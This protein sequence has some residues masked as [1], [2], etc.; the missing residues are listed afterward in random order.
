MRSLS[1]LLADR[2]GSA[3]LEFAVVAPFLVVMMVGVFEGTEL[4]RA[5]MKVEHAAGLLVKMVAQQTASVTGGTS[6]TLGDLCTGAKLSMTPLPAGSF[7]SAIASLTKPQNGSNAAEDWES[8]T[9]CAT[10]STVLSASAVDLARKFVPNAGDS[11]IIASATYTYVA[12]T[13]LVL[14]SSYILTSVAYAR[15]RVNSTIVCTNTS[16]PDC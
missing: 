8:D 12:P 1:R 7:A 10:R 2:R 14:K 4:Y 11:V 3:A 9:S 16:S 13:S 5:Q 6:G 15:P